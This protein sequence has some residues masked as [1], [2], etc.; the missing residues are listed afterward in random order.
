MRGFHRDDGGN[1]AILFGLTMLPICVLVGSAVDYSRAVGLREYARNAADSAAL[2]VA[3]A[4]TPGDG[5]ALIRG[6]EDRIR[7]KFGA[8]A[9]NLTVTGGW[10]GTTSTYTVQINGEMKAYILP[11]VPGL[12][13]QSLPVKMEVKAER[14]PAKYETAA[15][16]M[17]QL[18]PEAAD[19]NRVYMYCYNPN[20]KTDADQGRRDMRPIADNGD[21]GLDY[22]SYGRPSCTEGEL[23]SYKL[24]NV[25]N[26]RATRSK[27]D[28][29][30]SSDSG[31]YT[32]QEVYEYYT[33]TTMDRGTKVLVNNLTGGRINSQ[34]NVTSAVDTQRY[35]L[36]ETIL[37][38]NLNEC[39]SQDQGGKLPNNHVTG[40]TAQTATG[41]CTEGKYMYYGY[42][43]RPGGDQDYDDIRLVISCPKEIK[44]TDKQVH[45]TK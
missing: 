9:Q 5:S 32:R 41:G 33:D 43:D 12:N 26:A 17:S 35:P 4:D 37:C 18:S 45:L 23:V 19:Y 11:A 42:E 21:P 15:P 36:L 29:T 24:R 22:S 6:V 44:I 39:K 2:A 7:A 31:Y 40:R 1:A 30:N 13:K 3:N 14:V 10:N 16:S 28:P 38:D 25:R 34:G 27:W 20:R 8:T